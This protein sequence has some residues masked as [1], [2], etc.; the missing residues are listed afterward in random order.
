VSRNLGR[1][2]C[3]FC[4]GGKPR[5]EEAPRPATVDDVGRW[6]NGEYLDL[7][8]ANAT[9]HLCEAKYL[10]WMSTPSEK[11]EPWI[12]DLSFRSTFND[13]P[14]DEDLPKWKVETHHVRS[15]PWKETT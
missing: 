7:S 14:G 6:P 2:D 10:A 15:G 9:C 12:F 11:E 3:Y 8:V 5:L 1:T 13:E 4:P